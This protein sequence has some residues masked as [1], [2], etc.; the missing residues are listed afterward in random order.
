MHPPSPKSCEVSATFANLS[1][2]TGWLHQNKWA[3]NK[4]FI[5]ECV[6]DV[7]RAGFVDPIFGYTP[8]NAVD[9]SNL[10]YREGLI[11]RNLNSRLRAVTL[12]LSEEMLAKGP[13][14]SVYAPEWVSS[15]AAALRPL[16]EFHGSE[17]LPTAAAR[18]S[19]PGIRH[20][21]VTALTFDD[22]C[23]DAYVTNEV[24][25]HVPSIEPALTEAHRV[26]KPGG[27]FFGT[28]PMAYMSETTVKKA[29]LVDGEIIHLTPPEYHGN[30]VDPAGGS[31]VFNVPGWDILAQ[32]RAA[33]FDDVHIRYISSRRHAIVATELAGIL[34][35]IAR[36]G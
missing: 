32:A 9:A 25:E 33:G 34:V 2:W 17:Y 36:R 12:V 1:E 13:S 23:F 18:A 5:V 6:A 30:P 27:V 22:C 19:H 31:L 11:A 29:E 3:F 4:E 16:V 7:A 14:L 15:F 35:F 26:L 24:M 28:F 10:N 8:P 21:D 20:E